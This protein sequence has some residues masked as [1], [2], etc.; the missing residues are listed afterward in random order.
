MSKTI[1]EQVNDG[2]KL[3]KDKK[4]FTKDKCEAHK[5]CTECDSALYNPEGLELDKQLRSLF[6][7]K[8]EHMIFYLYE[9]RADSTDDY[10]ISIAVSKQEI[11]DYVKKH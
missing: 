10:I 4:N 2:I 1:E 11:E 6:N 5:K 7:S 8:F 3:F 9:A